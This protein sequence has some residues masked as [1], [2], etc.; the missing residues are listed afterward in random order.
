MM[1]PQN[2]NERIEQKITELELKSWHISVNLLSA[3][4]K[5]KLTQVMPKGPLSPSLLAVTTQT[6]YFKAEFY[7]R[8]FPQILNLPAIYNR[9]CKSWAER[10]VKVLFNILLYQMFS[11]LSVD[12]Q[13]FI[14]VAV[15]LICR[16]L[17]NGRSRAG[18][19]SLSVIVYDWNYI[20][21]TIHTTECYIK[22]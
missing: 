16:N 9:L 15:F 17:Q 19:D 14:I 18:E 10:T 12:L 4:R 7:F 13:K 21:P 22:F 20:P 1:G 3:E 5:R 6:F 2:E 11:T 8:G